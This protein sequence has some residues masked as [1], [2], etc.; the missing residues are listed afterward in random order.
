MMAVVP[1]RP[2][3]MT[4]EDDAH[5][6]DDVHEDHAGGVAPEGLVHLQSAARELIGLARAVLDLAEELVEDPSA[7]GPLAD[8]LGSVVRTAAR[9]GRRAAS[10]FNGDGGDE[11]NAGDAGESGRSHVQRIRI[12]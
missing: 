9:A 4:A 3:E 12:G 1:D 7:V 11:D 5:P 6:D 2:E 10:G 8:A